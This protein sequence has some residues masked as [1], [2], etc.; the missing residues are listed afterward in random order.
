MNPYDFFKSSALAY[1]KRIAVQDDVEQLSYQ[2][3]DQIIETYA[4]VIE[5]VGS[6]SQLKVAV[7]SPNCAQAMMCMLAI[8]RA[9]AVWVPVNSRNTIA[10]N[11]FILNR[12]DVD[13]LLLHSDYA[14]HVD[15]IRHGVPGLK[16]IVCID[17]S[18]PQAGSI[19]D[20][21]ATL[22][23]GYRAADRCPAPDM[24]CAML[25]TGGTTGTPK[26]V[27]WSES[28]V[29]TM[30]ASFWIHL[31]YDD[32]PVYLAAAPLTHAAGVIAL[33]LLARGG[34][35]LIHK[36]A[37][38]V[39]I[40]RV[41]QQHRVTH[42]F[43]PPTV[44]YMMLAHPNVREYNYASLAYFIYTAAP[45]APD[46]IREAMAV[47]G[48]VM[49]QVYGQAEVPLMCTCFRP[50][51]HARFLRDGNL[52]KFN[53]AGQPTLLTQIGVMSETGDILPAGALGEIVVRGQLVMRGYYNS[54]DETAAASKH[55]W[56][57]TGDIGYKDDEGFLYIVD[58]KKDM[59]ITGGFNV[60][61]TEVERVVL[62]HETVQ[63]CAVVGIPDDKWGEAVT[64]VIEAKP[65][66][67]ID[68]AALQ[69]H[70][71]EALGGVKTPKHFHVWES[72]P[73]S[74]VGKVLKREIREQFWAHR[75]RR[76]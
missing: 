4:A 8:F 5:Y 10:E 69:K 17:R 72:L 38:P 3:V 32:H 59:I 58:R 15:A 24:L 29:E 2:E 1:P 14:E 57:H 68:I 66:R 51:A 63:D 53:S 67:T 46:K 60:F 34:S 16:R 9:N 48:P 26:A 11:I 52:D 65:G 73:R 35:V 22:P 50:E 23:P 20:V 61:S 13:V 25:S 33:C 41:I 18:L 64:A 39:E 71:R 42:L 70:C 12:S 28:V 27:M 44:I 47:F 55:G 37:K 45:M 30:I 56:H 74:S 36:A 21:R 49:T 40:M 7:F 43:L 31:P 19:Q 6:G 76:I 54:P 75:E 62:Q